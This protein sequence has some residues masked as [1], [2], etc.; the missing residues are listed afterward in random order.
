VEEAEG[1]VALP[2]I[3]D[4]GTVPGPLAEWTIS[5]HYS[6]S[7]LS[8]WMARDLRL[9]V[10]DVTMPIRMGIL[11]EN[12]GTVYFIASAP[13]NR[14]QFDPQVSAYRLACAA[15]CKRMRLFQRSDIRAYSVTTD[16]LGSEC[17][18]RDEYEEVPL[19]GKDR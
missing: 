10:G 1:L 8:S 3:D 17:A 15:P 13:K 7:H 2:R 11:C 16:A 18:R 4:C 5:L 12:C 6:A 14:I 9:W 19:S